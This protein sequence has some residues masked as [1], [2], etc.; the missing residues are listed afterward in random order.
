MRRWWYQFLVTTLVCHAVPP[1]WSTTRCPAPSSPLH[2]SFHP[3]DEFYN[4]LSISLDAHASHQLQVDSCV[5]GQMCIHIVCFKMFLLLPGSTEL[6]HSI[7][8]AEYSR[9]Y[10]KSWCVLRASMT[11]FSGLMNC[12]CVSCKATQRC[13]IVPLS[14]APD[15][16][17][18]SWIFSFVD[19]ELGGAAQDH[20]EQAVVGFRTL[21]NS[22]RLSQ[23]EQVSRQWSSSV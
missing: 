15:F 14:F 10:T 4:V 16:I 17:P 23:D 11:G 22:S 19:S 21:K 3:T 9:A 7:S 12:V 5:R 13:K 20:R 1:H 8:G 2:H 18:C 6:P